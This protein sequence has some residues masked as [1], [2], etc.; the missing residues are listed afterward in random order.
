MYKACQ[1]GKKMKKYIFILLLFFFGSCFAQEKDVFDYITATNGYISI[2]N[3]FSVQIISS[4]KDQVYNV[5]ND[6]RGSVDI[7]AWKADKKFVTM[8]VRLRGWNTDKTAEYY[9]VI[10]DCRA[11]KPKGSSGGLR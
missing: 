11:E 1:E 9:S 6:L 4:R 7:V 8:I 10:I 2:N 5:F 3:G